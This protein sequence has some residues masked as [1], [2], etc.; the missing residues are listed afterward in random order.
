MLL[1]KLQVLTCGSLLYHV[2]LRVLPW[3]D[4]DQDQ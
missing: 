3:D 2:S 1:V 4:P